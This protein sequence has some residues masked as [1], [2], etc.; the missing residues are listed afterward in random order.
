MIIEIFSVIAVLWTLFI[1]VEKI[2][3]VPFLV[4]SVLWAVIWII[5][6]HY[7]WINNFANW[8]LIVSVISY[9]LWGWKIP[10]L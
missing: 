8:I 10:K 6:Y 1:I 2:W 9:F 5:S 3:K 7:Y 4:I